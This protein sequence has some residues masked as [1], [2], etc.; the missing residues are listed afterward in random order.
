MIFV[1]HVPLPENSREPITREV[2]KTTFFTA[3]RFIVHTLRKSRRPL[4]RV[5]I[6]S[7]VSQTLRDVLLEFSAPIFF[8]GRAFVRTGKFHM[9]CIFSAKIRISHNNV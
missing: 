7:S 8:R 5:L 4:E 3:K 9:Q 2:C 1:A 6:V